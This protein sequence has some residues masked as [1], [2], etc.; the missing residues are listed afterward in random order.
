MEE[1]NA[2]FLVTHHISTPKAK[3]G[4][5]PPIADVLKYIFSEFPK[6]CRS[7]CWIVNRKRADKMV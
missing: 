3:P 5:T 6:S 4:D 7:S 2:A 1:T